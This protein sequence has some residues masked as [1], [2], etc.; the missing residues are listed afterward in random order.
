MSQITEGM[1]RVAAR[2]A[3]VRSMVVLPDDVLARLETAV[4]AESRPVAKRA[5]ETMVRSARVAREQPG[6]VV[7]QDTGI[8]EFLVRLGLRATVQGDPER[9]LREVVQDVTETFPL[10]PHCADPF[11]RANTGNNVGPG[12]PLVRYEVAPDAD[13]L[14]ITSL[15]QSGVGT[16]QPVGAMW[17]VDDVKKMVLSAVARSGNACPPFVIGVGIG[18]PYD[19]AA[20]LAAKAAA[21]PLDVRNCD[22]QLAALE[23]KLLEQVNRLGIGP[24]NLGGDTTAL[25]VNVSRSYGHNGCTPVAVKVECWCVRRATVRFHPDGRCEHVQGWKDPC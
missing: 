1:F 23:A 22:P 13:Y 25:A 6:L 19:N 20:R 14:E 8:A 3:F 12:V 9:V 17:G 10:I 11:T 2:E 21:R 5:L 24:M 7:C 4:D 15:P 18:G 16:E